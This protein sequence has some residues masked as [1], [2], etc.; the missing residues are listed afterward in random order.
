ML[1]VVCIMGTIWQHLSRLHI[2]TIFSNQMFKIA[3][4]NEICKWPD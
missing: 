4:T 1:Y 3:P 2:G